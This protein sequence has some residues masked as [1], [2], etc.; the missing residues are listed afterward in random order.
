MSTYICLLMH[1]NTFLNQ[2][3]QLCALLLQG[4]LNCQIRRLFTGKNFGLHHI[5]F[6]HQGQ[7]PAVISHFGVLVGP[8]RPWSALVGNSRLQVGG[9]PVPGKQQKITSRKKS[10]FENFCKSSPGKMGVL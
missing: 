8:S 4:A 9:F 7:A 1:L 5:L 10:P 3:Q 2:G 6:P